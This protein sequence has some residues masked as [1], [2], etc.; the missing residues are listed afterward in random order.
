MSKLAIL[1]AVGVSAGLCGVAIGQHKIDFD[2]VKAPCSFEEAEPIKTDQYAHL[3]AYFSG[4]SRL[5][6]PAI[7]DECASFD[8]KARSRPN[9]LA[10]GRG[11]RMANGGSPADPLIVKF[12]PPMSYVS[13]YV[14]GVGELGAF[15]LLAFDDQNQEV[16][17]VKVESQG[18]WVQMRVEHPKP[19][20][21]EGIRYIEFVEGAGIR[22][23]VID[24][25]EFAP[26]GSTGC[27]PDCDGSG[28]LDFFDF[29]C[30]Q[31]AFLAGDPYADCDES[32][33]LDF[34]DFLCFQNEFLAG[35][36]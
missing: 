36:R 17:G 18:D 4:P 16:D 29:L 11:F 6:G 1:A 15:R 12:D 32:G 3:G 2:D 10:F 14:A 25:M 8:I 9:F 33:V 20:P 21:E 7:L 24:D 28:V 31:N 5:D 23:F 27:Y 13:L 19:T 34:F 35:C 22:I 30:F 26:A